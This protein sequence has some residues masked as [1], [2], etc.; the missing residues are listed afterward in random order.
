MQA[1][2]CSPLGVSKQLKLSNANERVGNTAIIMVIVRRVARISPSI[3]ITVCFN[4]T[5][6]ETIVP[7]DG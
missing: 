1:H 7:L 5:A 6:N 4:L 2:L 3:V